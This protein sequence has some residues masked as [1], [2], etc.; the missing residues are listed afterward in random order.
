M[1]M[2]GYYPASRADCAKSDPFALSLSKGVLL[3]LRGAK[4]GL[5]RVP[6]KLLLSWDPSQAQPERQRA[7]IPIHLVENGS[8][9]AHVVPSEASRPAADSSTVRFRIM[10][11]AP[12]ITVIPTSSKSIAPKKKFISLANH[13]T[14]RQ[15]RAEPGEEGSPIWARELPL[16]LSR[17][18]QQHSATETVSGRF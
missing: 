5:Q 1:S 14:K 11:E 12:S 16:P 15:G 8:E 6:M 13:R 4:K 2:L 7:L 17:L 3:S 10:S 9:R 18:L